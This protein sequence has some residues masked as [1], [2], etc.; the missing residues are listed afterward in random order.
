MRR[1]L[2]RVFILSSL[3]LAAACAGTPVGEGPEARA[4]ASAADD[5]QPS[6]AAAFERAKA[7][8][9][10]IAALPDDRRTFENTLDAVDATI[11]TLFR[12][13]RFT[14]F[15]K[16]VHP[17][18]AVRAEGN[19]VDAALSNWFNELMLNEGLY[20]AVRAYADTEPAL[21][22]ERARLLSEFLRD[23]R[24]AGMELDEAQRARVGELDRQLVEV[25]QEFQE[26][27]AGDETLVALTADELAGVPADVLASYA[28]SSDLYLV[29]MAYPSVLPIF[30]RCTVP[31]TRHKVSLAFS[32][33]GGEANVRVIERMIALRHERAQLLG[34][35]TT[36]HYETEVRMAKDPE[37]VMAFYAELTPKLRRKSIEDVAEYTAAKR[38]DTGDPEAVLNPWDRSFY[39]D[40]L[41]R[42]HYA[43]DQREVQQYFPIEAV[44]GGIF[45]LTQEIF[46][47]RFVEVTEL[48]AERGRPLWHPDVR[49]FDVFD[50]ASAEKLGEFYID[51]YPRPGKYS[52]AAQFPLTLR[53]V[54]PDGTVELPVVALV[55]NFTKPTA[56]AP[57]LLTHG[58]VETFFHEFGHCMHSILSDVDLA[59]FAGTQVARDFVEAPS[60]M[61]ENW[62]WNADVLNRFARHHETGEPLP[63]EL[64]EGLIAAKNLGSGY[65]NE[66]QLYLGQMDMAFHMDP[67]GDVDTAAVAHEV[68]ARSCLLP[69]VEGSLGYASFGHLNGYQAGYYGYLWSLV[70]A[71]DMFTP[72]A[73]GDLLDPELGQR[74]RHT[75]LA[76][77]GTV[78]AI[79]LVREFLGREPNSDAFL[80]HLGLGE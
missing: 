47:L 65:S 8:I 22:G 2:S 79:D 12:E 56:D 26:N 78:D 73:D 39:H 36:A 29:D 11:A 72:F 14:G 3:A 34:Y 1:P 37:T 15:M 43:V 17:D 80:E 48:A 18:P 16:D 10:T 53:K 38:E 57:S 19:E 46:G 75:V 30:Q 41:M 28:R 24:R 7:S 45:D 51:L 64:L 44:L 74:Y 49:L 9:D 54:H 40:Y 69:W 6:M 27:I 76:R 31:E 52:H 32:R 42:T 58:E 67:D 21:E 71:Q 13:V 33:R 70:Y 59:W 5:L 4:M 20:N 23:F 66:Y 61:L 55:C 77:G 62:I 50:S 63:A 25:G 60:Q 35:P 68:Y